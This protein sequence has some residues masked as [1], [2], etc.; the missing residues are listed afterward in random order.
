MQCPELNEAPPEIPFCTR[1]KA[2]AALLKADAEYKRKQTN[3]LSLI[4]CLVAVMFMSSI[5]PQAGTEEAKTAII[6]SIIGSL[7]CAPI[8]IL[9][10]IRHQKYQRW[11]VAEWIR[12][13]KEERS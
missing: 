6:T 5:L 1:R 12:L 8:I 4:W 3:Y 9:L 13:R 2:H 7:T 10:S 11:R